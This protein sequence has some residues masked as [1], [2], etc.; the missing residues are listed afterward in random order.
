MFVIDFN[1]D[2]LKYGRKT[3]RIIDEKA[4]FSICYL[5]YM[6]FQFVLWEGRHH[7]K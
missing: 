3:S 4:Y 5:I 7:V 1:I 2:C 6:L